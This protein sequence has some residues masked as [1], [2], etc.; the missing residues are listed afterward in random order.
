MKKVSVSQAAKLLGISVEKLEILEK[1]GLI[2]STVNTEGVSSYSAEEITR[3]KSRRGPTLAE[4]AAQVGAQIQQEVFTG[5]SSLLRSR[6]TYTIVGGVVSSCLVLSFVILSILFYKYPLQMSDYFGYY[7]RFNSAKQKISL[8]N[9]KEGNVLAASTGPGVVSTH[10]TILADIIKPIAAASLIAVKAVDNQ[11][12]TQIVTNPAEVSALNAPTGTSLP[13]INGTN[14][15]NGADGQQ[16]L[17]GA[18]G[19]TGTSGANG[20]NG[21]N[22]S[23]GTSVADVLTTPGSIIIRNGTNTTVPLGAGSNGQVLTISSG[24][25]A[26]ETSSTTTATDFSGSLSGDVTGTQGLTTVA[27]INGS[28]L[29]TTTATSGNILLGNGTQWVTQALSNDAT[30]N[31]SGVLTLKNTG[32]PGTYGSA[33][34]IPVFVTDAQGRITGV[35]DTAISGLTNSNFSGSAGITNANLANSSISFSTGTTGSD[36]NISGSPVS[37][38]GTLTL[39]IPNASASNRGLLT[40]TDWSTFNGKQNALGYT[41]LNSTSNLSDLTS[42]STARTNLGLGTLAIQSG[43]F[44]GISSG[45]NTGDQTISLT[46]DVTGSGTSSFATTLK[47]VGTAGSYGSAT[48][49]PVLTTDAQGRVSGVTNTAIS[50]L[51]VSNFGS[52]NISQWTNNSGYITTSS[53]DTLTNKSLS[54]STNTLSNIPNSALTNSALTVSAG[55]GLANGGTVSLGGTVTLSLPNVGTAGTYGSATTIPIITTD[56]QGRVSEVT[57]TGISGLTASNLTAG[58][59]SSK[60]TSGTYSIDISGNAATATTA[61]SANSATTATNFSGSLAGDVTGTQ[62][63]TS[64]AKINGAVLGTTTATSGNLLIGSGTQWVTQ[65]LSNDATINS[66]G[67]LTLK[68]TG[69]PGT[70][71]SASNIPVF[72]TDAQGRVTSVTNTAIS[73]LTVSNFGSANISQWTNNSGYLTSEAD[74][75]ASVTGRGATTA[76]ALT[77]SSLSNAITAGT[78]TATGGTING[79]TIGATTPSTG[80]FTTVNGLTFTNNGSNTLNIA[81]GKSLTVN[82]SITFGGT[83]GTTFTLPAA[84]D[85][86]IGRISTD[87]LTNKTIAA[88]SNTISGLTTTNFGSANISQW[89]NNSGFISSEV[90]TLASVSGRGAATSTTLTL[91]GGINTTTSNINFTVGGTDSSG[92]V[93]I[94]NSGTAT[95]DLLVLDNGTADPTGVSGGMYYNTTS[96][97][98][99]C[100][101]ASLWKDCDTG[102]S[103]SSIVAKTEASD[104]TNTSTT[105]QNTNLSFAIGAGETWSVWYALRAFNSITSSRDVNFAISAPAGAS[106]YLSGGTLNQS[107]DDITACAGT[108]ITPVIGNVDE[109]EV[110]AVTVVNGGTPGTITLQFANSGATGTAHVDAGSSMKAFKNQGSDVAE[111]YYTTDNNINPGSVVTVDPAITAGVKGATR[112]YDPQTLGVL[113]TLPGLVLGDSQ[114]PAGTRPVYLAL[115]GRVPVKVSTV[116]G[117]INAGDYLTSSGTNGVAMK[118]TQAGA[119]IG[120]A[121]TSFDGVGIGQVLVFIKNGSSTGSNFDDE[122]GKN[123]LM[124]W[125]DGSNSTIDNQVNISNEA[126]GVASDSAQAVKTKNVIEIKILDQI[127]KVIADIFNKTIEFFG[128]VIFHADVTFLGRPTFNK[129][130]AGHALIKA[131]DNEISITFEKEYAQ[132]PVVTA[133][134]NLVG[135]IKIDEIPGYAVYDLT[136]KG[137]KIKLSKP[138][139]FD[140]SFSWIA[141]GVNGDTV[142]TSSVSGTSLPSPIPTV[143]PSATPSPSPEIVPFQTATESASPSAQPIP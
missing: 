137:F 23:N 10:I 64:V 70:Y 67:A 1:Q 102:V 66:S 41:P 108:F 136:T 122:N 59:F 107:G 4:Q 84:S 38:G 40:S 89:T 25:P 72:V 135:D 2:H 90:D 124:R 34:N 123:V 128:N 16:G 100:F 141:L 27:K 115:S 88:G 79:T 133:N 129:D 12:Y 58:D 62:G 75:L 101:E 73:G 97:K 86:L 49:I 60:I 5:V 126:G 6:K 121:M 85:T 82:N 7:Y 22:G 143:I 91:N 83:D 14:G 142:S 76:T 92:K 50:G 140:M 33:V 13:G 15:A 112:P 39:N 61:T 78:L 8:S 134:V 94:G 125:L 55:T 106:C 99:R 80:V 26:W 48:Q 71:G 52:A 3:I 110:L 29:G 35:T 139:T 120:T 37:L 69:T 47:N 132:N 116:N 138:T 118:A 65:A 45:T 43:T 32:T 44:S 98:F 127:T 103:Q 24:I 81:A 51:T 113:S 17:T 130:T 21:S 57:A 104:L 117:K 109:L 19:L 18:Q 46:G 30:I 68:N 95:P 93:Q 42:A 63:S 87:T 131:G 53:T 9:E 111:I 114:V 96:G 54:G 20:T 28:V 119:I 56:A 77:L 105:L 31:S 74:T 36:F 11:K